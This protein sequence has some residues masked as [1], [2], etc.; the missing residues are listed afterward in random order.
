MPSVGIQNNV[1]K[2]TFM[3]LSATFAFSAIMAYI[4]IALSVP[5][6][7][8]WIT[9]GVYIAIL[10]GLHFNQNNGFAVLFCFALTG[11]LGFTAGPI[12]AAVM[13][14]KPGVVFSAF[15]LATIM[16]LGLSA[17]AAISKRDFS[18]MGSFLTIG[19][20]VAFVAGLIAMFFSLPMLGLLVSAG[21]RIKKKMKAME[22][23]LSKLLFDVIAWAADIGHPFT[24][25]A[26]TGVYNNKERLPKKLREL[27]KYDLDNLLN[28]LLVMEKIGKHRLKDGVGKAQWLDVPGGKFSKG[29]G[30]LASGLAPNYG[31]D[32]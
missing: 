31:E 7:G 29:E 13:A 22:S 1:L 6:I 14:V 2:N 25:T 24:M 27:S 23:D 30:E 3:L 10:V 18:F 16:F 20:L 9:L 15:T 21:A 5:F 32:Y 26:G 4:A 12:L 28:D 11:W 8:P 17:Y 19:I